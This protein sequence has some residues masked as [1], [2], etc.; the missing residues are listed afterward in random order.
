MHE[1]RAARLELLG[2]Y[3]SHPEGENKPSPTD[4]ARAFYPDAAYF[5]ISVRGFAERGRGAAG[6]R[7]FD[8]RW[9]R[10]GIEDRSSIALSAR[11]R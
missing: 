11:L 5:I 6:S 7:V 1:I 3:H 4:I 8:P 2:I 10:H 9:P